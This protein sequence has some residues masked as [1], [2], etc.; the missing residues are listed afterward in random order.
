MQKI[1]VI[2]SKGGCGKTTL[3]TNIAS[4]FACLK[5]K[6]AIMDYDPQGSSL[7]W[8]RVRPENLNQVHG[9]DARKQ[10]GGIMRSWKMNV[11]VDTEKLVIDA[12]AGM[13]NLLLQEM[14]NKASFIVIPVTP[15][16]IDIHASAG[17]IK[18][19]LLIGKIRA[20][21]TNLAIVA[22]R[23]RSSAA[24]YQPLER[25]LNALHIPLVATLSDSEA[26]VHAAGEG[27]GIYDLTPAENRLEKQELRP[28]FSWLEYPSLKA[29]LVDPIAGANAASFNDPKVIDIKSKT[30]Q[31]SILK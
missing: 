19:L 24:V 9:A 4:Y 1:L 27:K 14:V 10:K 5:Y 7:Q 3:A 21:N 20:K 26:Y 16:G 12:P 11:P 18:D 17:F 23:V 29:E 6:T 15:S 31:K 13:D 22:N 28:L 8:C 2:N 30:I 25:F